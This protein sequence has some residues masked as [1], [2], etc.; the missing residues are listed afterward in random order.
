MCAVVTAQSGIRLSSAESL[1]LV[2]HLLGACLGSKPN[3]SS[4][5]YIYMHVYEI[6]DDCHHGI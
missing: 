5:E 1:V 2:A 6:Y 3:L 4:A